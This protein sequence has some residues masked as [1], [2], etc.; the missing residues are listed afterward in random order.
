MQGGNSMALTATLLVATTYGRESNCH[1]SIGWLLRSKLSCRL[2]KTATAAAMSA[3]WAPREFPYEHHSRQGNFMDTGSLIS[4]VKSTCSFSWAPLVS[5]NWMIVGAHALP[6]VTGCDTSLFPCLFLA[7]LHC[8]A[9]SRD[10]GG[11]AFWRG[12][13]RSVGIRV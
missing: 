1:I 3:C 9:S 5:S 10:C 12:T 2:C 13:L 6:M 7:G 8:N 4:L 11:L